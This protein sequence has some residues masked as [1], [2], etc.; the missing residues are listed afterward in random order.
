MLKME[1]FFDILGEKNV[2]INN[3]GECSFLEVEVLLEI[4]WCFGV[5]IY[6][7]KVGAMTE[8]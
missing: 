7:N 5:C 8:V 4:S 2:K 6:I 1:C 3:D